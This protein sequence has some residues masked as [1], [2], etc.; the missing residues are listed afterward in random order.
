MPENARN[1]GCGSADYHKMHPINLSEIISS[2]YYTRI[3]RWELYLNRGLIFLP[4]PG[5]TGF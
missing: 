4:N 3:K 1:S 5:K 2:L